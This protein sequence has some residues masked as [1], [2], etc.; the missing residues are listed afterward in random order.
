MLRKAAAAAAAGASRTLLAS[1]ALSTSA[2]ACTREAIRGIHSQKLAAGFG[3]CQHW[4]PAQELVHRT[5][6]TR[7]LLAP[8]NAASGPVRSPLLQTPPPP[9]P[10]KPAEEGEKIE[11]LTKRSL[12]M[13][14]IKMNTIAKLIRGLSVDNAMI[15][16]QLNPKRAAK[17]VLDFLKCAKGNAIHNKSMDSRRLYVAECFIGRATP[18]RR[19][20]MHGR[21]RSGEKRRLRTHL[22]VVLKER[23]TNIVRP[24]SEKRIRLLREAARAAAQLHSSGALPEEQSDTLNP[25]ARQYVAAANSHSATQPST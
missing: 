18:I 10:E 21:G 14:P 13:S 20:S 2:A 25:T 3:N 12:P 24:P 22:S 15:Q 1:R 23:P 7:V 9:S 17:A 16:L 8:Q 4:R 11:T 5:L 6:F 19:V